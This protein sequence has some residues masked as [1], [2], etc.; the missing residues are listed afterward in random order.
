[1]T[2]RNWLTVVTV[3]LLLPSC[4]DEASVDVSELEAPNELIAAWADANEKCMG[5]AQMGE[6]D[7]AACDSAN[8]LNEKLTAAGFCYGNE[9]EPRSNWKW[10]PCSE[11]NNPN[12][13]AQEDANQV[14]P[15][16]REK[17]YAADLVPTHGDKVKE[18]IATTHDCW[19]AMNFMDVISRRADYQNDM[20]TEISNN[21]IM[22]K[23]YWNQEYDSMLLLIKNEGT[24]GHKQYI[25]DVAKESEYFT[26]LLASEP[27]SEQSKSWSR[28]AAKVANACVSYIKTTGGAKTW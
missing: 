2:T 15:E 16:G 25:I 17:F 5:A 24:E 4:S 13:S 20:T 19:I 22:G 26:G 1:M 23:S 8:K 11:K 14:A 3:G 10:A 21:I 28:W 12:N 27:R 18:N 9:N 6:E 7:P